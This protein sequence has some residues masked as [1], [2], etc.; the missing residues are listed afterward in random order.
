ML[1]KEF[2]DVYEALFKLGNSM[3]KEV[4]D[5]CKKC[6]FFLLEVLVIVMDVLL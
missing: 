6:P 4:K 3:C 1:E 5:S 2:T